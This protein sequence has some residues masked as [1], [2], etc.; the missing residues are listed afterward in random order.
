M[1]IL[2]LP[3]Q[4]YLDSTPQLL[5]RICVL[6][7]A[8]LISIR[9]EWLR[10]VLLGAEKNIGLKLAAIGVFAVLAIIGTHTGLVLDLS[11]E[12]PGQ[13]SSWGLGFFDKLE[14]NQAIMGFRDTITMIAGMMG[15]PWVGFGVGLIAGLDRYN[16]GGFAGLA[17]GVATL[18]L[19]FFAGLV[20]CYRPLWVKTATGVFM[21]ALT[22]TLLHRLILL[23]LV[24]PFDTALLLT[25]NVL[26][27][28]AVVNCLGCVLF[29]WVMRD[30]EHDRLE[31]E[32]KE[33]KLIAMKA[34]HE[35]DQHKLL[36]IQAQFSL[37]IAQID[38]HF[39]NNCLNNLKWV[40]RHDPDKARAYVTELGQFYNATRQFSGQHFITVKDELD[41]LE[42]Y[43]SLQRLAMGQKQSPKL[44][45]TIDIPNE[46]YALQIIP[47]SLI[48][49]VENVFKH[50][51]DP[52]KDF[53]QLNI[54]A[55]EHEE[56]L[57]F[58]VTDNGMGIAAERLELLGKHQVTSK[59][60]GGGVA[61]YQLVRSLKLKFGEAASLTVSSQQDVGTTV[62]IKQ[63]KGSKTC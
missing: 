32:A 2:D 35:R 58:R 10:R 45:D 8:A 49:L 13:V 17:S 51:I 36:A 53:Y 30:L 50:G 63:P 7:V 24:K 52:R 5:L 42:R 3:W 9:F 33:A 54:A 4:N 60:N 19:G 40:I 12:L 34:I 38:P 22:G 44:Q 55:E 20:R 41:Q 37:L 11:P 29:F 21:I 14:S 59:D 62:T 15:G 57:V 47:F 23:L 61:L 1:S 48:T 43:L 28:V 18:I 27:P 6:I 39:L 46:L 25:L 26:L 31:N 16:L 56:S